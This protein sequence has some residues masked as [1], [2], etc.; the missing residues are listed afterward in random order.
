VVIGA[1]GG[2]NVIHKDR[3]QRRRSTKGEKNVVHK[4]NFEHT[5]RGSKLLSMIVAFP[6]ALIC[7]MHSYAFLFLRYFAC[8]VTC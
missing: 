3:T 6:C 5:S 4:D 1:K 7:M 2:E 8:V